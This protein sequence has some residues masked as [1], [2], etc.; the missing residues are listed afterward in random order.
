MCLGWVELWNITL[1]H[2]QYI[3]YKNKDTIKSWQTRWLQMSF[4]RTSCSFSWGIRKVFLKFVLC[5]WYTV[6]VT[7]IPMNETFILHFLS[8][9]WY[10]IEV[11]QSCFPAL[12]FFSKLFFFSMSRTFANQEKELEPLTYQLRLSRPCDSLSVI[13]E[14]VSSFAFNLCL[15]L[16]WENLLQ[17]LMRSEIRIHRDLDYF[18]SSWKKYIVYVC[19]CIYGV[20]GKKKFVHLGWFSVSC[21]EFCSSKTGAV[22]PSLWLCDAFWVLC[23]LVTV[24]RSGKWQ[25]ARAKWF[26]YTLKRVLCDCLVVLEQ[27]HLMWVLIFVKSRCN[28]SI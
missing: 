22:H 5:S 3:S 26:L 16:H 15:D 13:S 25:C 9:H 1:M 17:L 12:Y 23:S 2:I 14:H 20:R 19:I 4:F 10:W 28:T 8:L 6:C 24:Q 7:F 11:L 18:V 27:Y 21:I